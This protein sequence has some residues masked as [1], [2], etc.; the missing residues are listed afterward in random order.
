MHIS[1]CCSASSQA[2]RAN[3]PEHSYEQFQL[4]ISKWKKEYGEIDANTFQFV[5]NK[6]EECFFRQASRHP[7]TD[8]LS[9]ELNLTGLGLTSIPDV[10]EFSPPTLF[11]INVSGNALNDLP[12]SLTCATHLNTLKV[13]YNKFTNCPEIITQLKSLEKL[14]FNNNCLSTLPQ[15]FS[16]LEN[17]KDV[18]FDFNMFENT[19]DALKQL[20]LLETVRINQIPSEIILIDL[21]NLPLCKVYGVSGKLDRNTV[22]NDKNLSFKSNLN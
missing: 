19:P 10:F 18:N 12:H 21:I 6:F 14:D 5:T 8:L 22:L 4:K 9:N 17:L 3:L 11:C 20:F 15:S 1:K 13:A 7:R 16:N 2:F